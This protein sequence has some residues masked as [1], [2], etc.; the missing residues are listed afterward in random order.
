MNKA[1]RSLLSSLL[2]NLLFLIG[3]QSSLAAQDVEV[4]GVGIN[5]NGGVKASG[6]AQAFVNLYNPGEA[7]E[8]GVFQVE[9]SRDVN[10]D[11]IGDVQEQWET[12]FQ[13]P[14]KSSSKI[15]LAIQ[16]PSASN[17]TT[18]TQITTRVFDGARKIHDEKA[19]IQPR[20]EKTHTIIVVGNENTNLHL[21]G[22]SFDLQNLTLPV[23]VVDLIPRVMSE[24]MSGY[25]GVNM[26]VL[27]DAP[28]QD[29]TSNQI[30]ALKNWVRKGGLLL[31]LAES[32]VPEN[33]LLSLSP[34]AILSHTLTLDPKPLPSDLGLEKR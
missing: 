19:F 14:A 32:M 29:L 26:V 27:A 21:P 9:I 17:R 30:H 28:W 23:R 7:I 20:A 6:N 3:V 31:V 5:A 10:N 13:L 24:D 18:P 15:T 34:D 2:L 1:T 8:A 16:A 12:L 11:G 4:R 22:K 25:D 33:P